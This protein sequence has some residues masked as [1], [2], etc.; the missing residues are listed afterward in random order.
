[1]QKALDMFTAKDSIDD[2]QR[3]DNLNDMAATVALAKARCCLS[4]ILTGGLTK[5]QPGSIRTSHIKVAFL[6]FCTG[7]SS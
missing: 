6:A 5:A 3:F 7:R 4:R 1:M 2:F